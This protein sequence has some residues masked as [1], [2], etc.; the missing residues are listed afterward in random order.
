[1]ALATVGSRGAWPASA[2][3][4]A[5]RDFAMTSGSFPDVPSV[6]T[7]TAR[8][9]R[10]SSESAGAAERPRSAK[11]RLEERADER[12]VAAARVSARQIVVN[13]RQA[14]RDL[15]EDAARLLSGEAV[16]EREEVADAV[17]ARA[18]ERPLVAGERDAF[19]C[20]E[21]ALRV[22]GERAKH[23]GRILRPVVPERARVAKSTCGRSRATARRVQGRRSACSTRQAPWCPAIVTHIGICQAPAHRAR[24]RP[25]EQKRLL[26]ERRAAIPGSSAALERRHR[27]ERHA[28]LIH[29][30]GQDVIT[31]LPDADAM[32]AA[33]SSDVALP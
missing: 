22:A 12:F 14:V 5:A 23:V 15:V 26:I 20:G 8:S 3:S 19:R 7:I 33:K 24:R 31:G 27:H 18:D 25:V 4:R 11:L 6:S 10:R 9:A 28:G 1:M 29:E 13:E 16:A 21:R 17:A 30:R 2:R 32:A